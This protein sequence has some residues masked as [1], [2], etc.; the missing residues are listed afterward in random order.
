MFRADRQSDRDSL[1][2]TWVPPTLETGGEL[3]ATGYMLYCNEAKIM[4]I[5][6]ASTKQALLKGLDLNVPHLLGICTTSKRDLAT[7]VPF[8]S[9]ITYYKYA[10]GSKCYRAMRDYDPEIDSTSLSQP[11]APNTS[12]GLEELEFDEGDILTVHGIMVSDIRDHYYIYIGNLQ[13]Y[14]YMHM[15]LHQD[16]KMCTHQL[17]AV[18]ST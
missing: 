6:S 11:M 17:K 5:A 3:L 4:D 1:L 12:G 7:L 18:K 14:M 10:G 9:S 16:S 13:M 15:H 8:S 2:L